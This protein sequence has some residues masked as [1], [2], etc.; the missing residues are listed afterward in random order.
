MANPFEIRREM[1]QQNLKEQAAETPAEQDDVLSLTAKKRSR[2][3]YTVYLERDLM[4]RVKQV[5]MQRG[6]P[7]SAVVEACLKNTLDSLERRVE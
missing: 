3:S 4:A 6:V 7:V 1:R 5:A 2:Q